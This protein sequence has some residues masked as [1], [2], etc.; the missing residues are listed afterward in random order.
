MKNFC[1]EKQC[2]VVTN[3]KNWLKVITNFCFVD[4]QFQEVWVTRKGKSLGKN[5]LILKQQYW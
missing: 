1:H 5:T 2:E 3:S 4:V